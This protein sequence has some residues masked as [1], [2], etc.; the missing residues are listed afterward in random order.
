[1]PTVAEVRSLQERFGI[2]H[3]PTHIVL[4]SIVQASTLYFSYTGLPTANKQARHIRETRKKA[5][6]LLRALGDRKMVAILKEMRREIE[7]EPPGLRK[8]LYEFLENADKALGEIHPFTTTK[9]QRTGTGGP[10]GL[11]AVVVSL[12]DAL[13]W[14][15]VRPKSIYW[16][17]EYSK[18]NGG[19]FFDFV[20]E[21]CA[22]CG[23]RLSDATIYDTVKDLHRNGRL[24][25][26]ADTNHP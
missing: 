1:M 10:E 18:V 7:V 9:K 4:N 19:E 26:M 17:N 12:A 25:L 8:M 16:H 6:A 23:I 14:F 3:V 13:K 21:V 24:P 22:L 15:H 2:T 11:R 5:D 20:S